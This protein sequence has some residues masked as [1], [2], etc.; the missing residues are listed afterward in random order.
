MVKIPAV[1]LEYAKPGLA[2]EEA[3]RYLTAGTSSGL[4]SSAKPVID[5]TD[6]G[7]AGGDV[8]EGGADLMEED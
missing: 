7:T 4:S 2:R 3:L 6:I 1:V 8:V 5:L